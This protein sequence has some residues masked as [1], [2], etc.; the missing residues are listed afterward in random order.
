MLTSVL[1]ALPTAAAMALLCYS[2]YAVGLWA[3]GRRLPRVR[4]AAL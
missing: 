3:E 4:L 1:S 2:P